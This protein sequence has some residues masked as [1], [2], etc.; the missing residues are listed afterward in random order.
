MSPTIMALA[1]SAIEEM[2]YPDNLIT[3]IQHY[4]L[5]HGSGTIRTIQHVG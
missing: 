4:S 1:S 3:D 2:I 5:D